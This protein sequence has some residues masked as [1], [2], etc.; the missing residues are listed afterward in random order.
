MSRHSLFD[1]W[2]KT[3]A[4]LLYRYYT[5]DCWGSCQKC[6]C[7]I[8]HWLTTN[9]IPLSYNP[10]PTEDSPAVPHYKTCRKTGAA[11]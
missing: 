2:P 9:R 10:M 7:V 4:E 1:A 3:R 6:G 8:E 5:F 11:K